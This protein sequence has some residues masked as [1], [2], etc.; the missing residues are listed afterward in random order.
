VPHP[1][2]LPLPENLEEIIDVACAKKHSFILTKSGQLWATGN[3]KEE[4]NSR[5]QQI[6]KDIGEEELKYDMSDPIAK[7]NK[8]ELD[9]VV[10]E[11]HSYKKKNKNGKIPKNMI[12]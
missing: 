2:S 4:K 8:V 7:S 3:I 10:E 5:L 11:K 1:R 6:K 12:H 9:F